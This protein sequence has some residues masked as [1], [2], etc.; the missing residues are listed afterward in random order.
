MRINKP[1]DKDLVKTK[2]ILRGFIYA[3]EGAMP[4]LS[5]VSIVIY[6]F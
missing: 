1:I 5:L 3:F 2:T 6:L 4:M